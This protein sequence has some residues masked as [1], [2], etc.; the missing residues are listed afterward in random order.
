MSYVTNLVVVPGRT[1]QSSTAV[2][3]YLRDLALRQTPNASSGGTK[4]LEADVWTAGL[5][6]ADE[7]KLIEE[8]RAIPWPDPA[9]WCA[10]IQTEEWPARLVRQSAD[11]TLGTDDDE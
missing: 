11:V 1:N 5:N 9:S 3:E 7:G 8:L 2:R 4:V 6:Y 10:W